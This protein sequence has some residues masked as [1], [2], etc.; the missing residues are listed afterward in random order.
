MSRIVAAAPILARSLSRRVARA[1]VATVGLGGALVAGSVALSTEGCGTGNYYCDSSACYQCDGYGCHTVATPTVTPCTIAGDPVCTAPAVCTSDG[2]ANACSADTPC[3]QGLVCSAGYCVPPGANPPTLKTCDVASDCGANQLCVNG[4]CVNAPVCTGSECACKYTS[5]CGSGR[6]CVDSQCVPSCAKQ[7]DCP[8][9]LT[10]STNGY[11]IEGPT[12]DCGPNAGGKT[13]SAGQICV[14]AHCVD[15]CTT[16]AQCVGSDGKADPGLRCVAGGCVVDPTLHATC[17][18]DTT[19]IPN[20]QICLD[21]LCRYTCTSD[22]TCESIDN[23]IGTCSKTNG[24][25]MSSGEANAQCILK[26]DCG[27]G[28]DCVNG[29]CK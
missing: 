12:T 21:G 19:C 25:C 3:A 16:S 28:R 26:S 29:A 20:E 13:C 15:A 11:C 23:R 27:S 2:C 22:T 8:Q 1:L 4:T 9:G 14:D 5:D 10:C 18:D 7:S 17:H 24:V 6:I